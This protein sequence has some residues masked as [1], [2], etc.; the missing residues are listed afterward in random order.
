MGWTIVLV[1]V[2]AMFW[3]SVMLKTKRTWPPEKYKELR[4]QEKALTRDSSKEKEILE[5]ED[6]EDLF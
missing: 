4:S 5:E 1:I 2:A 6:W 3:G